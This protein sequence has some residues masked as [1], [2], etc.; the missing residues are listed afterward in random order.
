MTQPRSAEDFQVRL[1]ALEGVY[2]KSKDRYEGRDPEWNTRRELLESRAWR[3]IKS[4]GP[5]DKASKAVLIIGRLQAIAAELD[6]PR[7]NVMEY[8]ELH[9]RY[10]RQAET[11]DRQP[12][13]SL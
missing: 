8:E 9:K 4:F 1:K 6:Q 3:E 11:E 13:V 10:I 7:L 12:D 2:Q 5:D